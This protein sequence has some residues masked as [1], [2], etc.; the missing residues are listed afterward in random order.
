MSR[1]KEAPIYSTWQ[2]PAAQAQGPSTSHLTFTIKK[3]I[4]EIVSQLPKYFESV[5]SPQDSGQ[6]YI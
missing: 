2:T 3:N 5:P 1:E 6:F 4:Q